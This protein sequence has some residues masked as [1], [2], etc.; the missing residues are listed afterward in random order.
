MYVHVCLEDMR[1]YER[2]TVWLWAGLGS[3]NQGHEGGRPDAEGA[4]RIE[5]PAASACVE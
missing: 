2:L 3:G 4:R 5:A 1:W